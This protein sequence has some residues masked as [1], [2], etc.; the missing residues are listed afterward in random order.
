MK[1]NMLSLISL[2]QST[3]YRL[4]LFAISYSSLQYSPLNNLITFAFW[5]MSLKLTIDFK[6]FHIEELFPQ[7]LIN[8]A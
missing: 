6:H 4:R 2:T 8:L 5:F 1:G 3:K 7:D